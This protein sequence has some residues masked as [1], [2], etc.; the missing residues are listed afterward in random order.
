MSWGI[1]Q[2][3]VSL[4]MKTADW[5][6]S[7]EWASFITK[8]YDECMKRGMDLTTKNPIK[9]GN[10]ELMYSLLQ[11]TSQKAITSTTI[12]FYSQY[13]KL[14]GEAIKGYWMGAELQTVSIPV[15]PAI[16]SFMNIGVTS[17]SVTKPGEFTPGYTPPIQDTDVFIK[18]FISLAK[19]HLLN[20]EG[21]CQTIS[22]Y[23]PTSTPAPGIISWTGYKVED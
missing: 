10:T 18:Q 8:K 5:K 14:L 13:T 3:E 7:D 15:I 21:I 19:M 23:P 4:K 2:S 16:G 6:S 17:N 11:I 20:V 22:L 1:F 9:K 12:D